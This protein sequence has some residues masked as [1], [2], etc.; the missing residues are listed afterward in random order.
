MFSSPALYASKMQ[1]RYCSSVKPSPKRSA[2]VRSWQA[3]AA[4]IYGEHDA[5]RS[6]CA[7]NTQTNTQDSRKTKG[8]SNI[9]GTIPS[10]AM[11][12]ESIRVHAGGGETSFKPQIEMRNVQMHDTCW[13]TH[14]AVSHMLPIEDRSR[15][16]E[17]SHLLIECKR[18]RM[19]VY[20]HRLRR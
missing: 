9:L 20:V 2:S 7:F 18:A 6:T 17:R 1:S 12:K 14:V 5:R 13:W 3:A 19:Q 8:G 4:I 16:N 11:G 10:C 15:R